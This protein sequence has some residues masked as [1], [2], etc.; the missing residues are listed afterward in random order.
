MHWQISLKAPAPVNVRFRPE[1]ANN[2]SQKVLRHDSETPRERHGAFLDEIDR[3]DNL[4]ISKSDSADAAGLKSQM[5]APECAQPNN[6]A[7]TAK[8]AGKVEIFQPAIE[9]QSLIKSQLADVCEPQGHIASIGPELFHLYR[10]PYGF[11]QAFAESL[12][13]FVKGQTGATNT[14]A[15]DVS[16]EY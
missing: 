14:V 15:N 13:S 8:L 9:W 10:L 16:C 1:T 12:E 11:R 6:S 7:A 5:H 2:I 4:R 3:I